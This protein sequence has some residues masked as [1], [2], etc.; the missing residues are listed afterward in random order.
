MGEVYLCYLLYRDDLVPGV[1]EA[2]DGVEGRGLPGAR[3]SE[4]HCRVLV[5]HEE[6]EVGCY[7]LA[8]GLTFD[9]VHYRER[10]SPK[11]PDGE[12]RAGR[13][14]LSSIRDRQPVPPREGRIHYGECEAY[15]LTRLVHELHDVVVNLLLA[16]L[17]VRP[18]VLEVPVEHVEGL[19]EAG[20]ADV[21]YV[22][23]VHEGIDLSEARD[24]PL[25][26]VEDLFQA[27]WG[28]ALYHLLVLVQDEG[29]LL[30]EGLSEGLLL[31]RGLQVPLAYL[32]EI[33]EGLPL[34]HGE[35]QLVDDVYVVGVL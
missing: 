22:D 11:L 23:V 21:L 17:D 20:A 9:E 7:R 8:E 4:D 29:H 6:P 31:S 10:V 15:V 16:E 27:N 1:D 26:V 18:D 3:G 25:E 24:V 14:D 35:G 32:S 30:L 28:E 19:T 33:L 5:L 12:A 13:G 2:G 34:L